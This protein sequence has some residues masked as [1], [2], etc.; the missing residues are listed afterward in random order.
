MKTLPPVRRAARSLARRTQRGIG[1]FG[2]LFIAIVVGFFV[3]M[4][5]NITPTVMEYLSIRSAV[6]KIARENPS[7][8]AAVREAFNRQ[9]TADYLVGSVTAQDLDISKENGQLVIR[10]A[11]R[12]EI[13]MYGPVSL[14]ITYSGEGRAG[15]ERGG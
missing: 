5:L 7:T 12:K 6:N 15:A 3:W 2:L 9:M 8:V 1:L 4:G 14:V 10:F 13:P 11:Y